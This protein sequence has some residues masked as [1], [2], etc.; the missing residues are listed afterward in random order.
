MLVAATKGDQPVVTLGHQTYQA[1]PSP[2]AFPLW[3]RSNS[4]STTLE[5]IA[6]FHAGIAKAA[7]VDG[8]VPSLGRHRKERYTFTRRT[9]LN[10]L[11][12]VNATLKRDAE[13]ADTESIIQQGLRLFYLNKVSD[14]AD[15]RA[16]VNILKAAN[17]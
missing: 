2:P 9:L 17:L 6:T 4:L 3:Q 1:P 10:L 8:S 5:R 13:M 16:I 7:G 15:R 12:F 14:S 11:S